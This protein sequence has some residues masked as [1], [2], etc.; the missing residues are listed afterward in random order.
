MS[1]LP[2]STSMACSWTALA[3]ACYIEMEFSACGRRLLVV[4]KQVYDLSERVVTIIN[5]KY[6]E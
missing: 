1:P 3:V 6:E 4:T 2:P 5:N